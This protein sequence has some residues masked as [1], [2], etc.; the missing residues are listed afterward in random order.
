MPK[1]LPCGTPDTT[2]TSLLRQP[3]NITCC[4]QFDRNCVNICRQHRTS[5]THRAEL[6]EN[7]K[8]VDPFKGCT[9]VNLHDPNLMPTLQ[10]TLQCEG[11]AQKCITGMQTFPISKLGGLKHTT[12]FHKSSK[13]N[14][15]QALKHL[16]QYRCYGN[17][18]VIGNRRG[19]WTFRN[20]GDI[21]LSPASWETTLTNK[22]LKHYIKMGGP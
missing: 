15:Y 9:E 2:L 3:S 6:I 14:R 19:R 18:S 11:D 10:Y 8:M 17:W 22:P 13:T 16:G 5:N 21:G 4:D 7:A 1:A 12:A 20:W